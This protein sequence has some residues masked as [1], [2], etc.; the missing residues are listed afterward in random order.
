MKLLFSSC[1]AAC[2]LALCGCNAP[3]ST[4]NPPST[5]GG[6]SG[7]SEKYPSALY[8]AQP[9]YPSEL[10]R[11]GGHGSALVE[12]IV[13]EHGNVTKPRVVRASD[14]AFGQVALDCIMKWRFSPGMKNGRAV[15][16][17]MQQPFE[18]D[19]RSSGR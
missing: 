12:F 8:R 5:A 18:F 3:S 2:L 14:P 9:V 1:L 17:R 19:V 15:S 6:P 10:K 11:T 16:V 4:T 13:D 7:A